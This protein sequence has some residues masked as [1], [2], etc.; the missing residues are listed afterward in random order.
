MVPRIVPLN[1]CFPARR[2]LWDGCGSSEFVSLAST[3]ISTN[4]IDS[5]A[6]VENYVPPSEQPVDPILASVV[7]VSACLS[8]SCMA[9]YT[10]YKCLRA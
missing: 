5:L 1:V 10:R 8:T 6:L 7:S 2:R 4:S 3:D 9:N